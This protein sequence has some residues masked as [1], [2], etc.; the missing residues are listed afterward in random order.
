MNRKYG[1]FIDDVKGIE[2]YSEVISS[3]K[4]KYS[5]LRVINFRKKRRLK[6][7][8]K[9]YGEKLEMCKNNILRKLDDFDWNDFCKILENA[10]GI[11]VEACQ[12]MIPGNMETVQKYIEQIVIKDAENNN[13]VIKI[14]D[15]FYEDNYPMSTEMTE[16]E[17]YSHLDRASSKLEDL[18]YMTPVNVINAMKKYDESYVSKKFYNSIFSFLKEKVEEIA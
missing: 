12:F 3:L 4:I 9:Y 14:R 13:T 5:K 6:W 15:T 7:K 17:I 16:Y 8:I 2:V 10:D 18:E 11:K 1:V